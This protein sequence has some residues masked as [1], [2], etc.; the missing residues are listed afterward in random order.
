MTE[1]TMT[2]ATAFGDNGKGLNGEPRCTCG[3]DTVKVIL[4]GD[5]SNDGEG[6][7]EYWECEE[8]GTTWP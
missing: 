3:G 8:C 2:E 4:V 5:G 1:K 6:Y 7:D